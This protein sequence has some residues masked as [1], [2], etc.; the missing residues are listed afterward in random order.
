[1]GGGSPE[2]GGPLGDG[3]TNEVTR[4]MDYMMLPERSL[5]PR[6]GDGGCGARRGEKRDGGEWPEEGEERKL[7]Q[8]DG[9]WD[10]GTGWG[11]GRG[12]VWKLNRHPARDVGSGLRPS[13][14]VNG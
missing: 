1:M 5:C 2:E 9:D 12:C 14:I 11:A 7:P 6:P 13:C 10:G 8:S 4:T 3:A